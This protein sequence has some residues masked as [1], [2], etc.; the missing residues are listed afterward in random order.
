ET[1]LGRPARERE[2]RLD[3][4][5]FTQ[6]VFGSSS[7]N[8]DVIAAAR[9]FSAFPV[10]METLERMGIRTPAVYV[11]AAR[12]A[13]KLTS[14]DPSRGAVALGQF[15]GALALLERMTRVRTID[16][17]TAEAFAQRLFAVRIEDG[18]YDGSVAAWL[19]ALV[20]RVRTATGTSQASSIDDVILAA[21]A[22]PQ[23]GANAARLEWEG[24]RYRVDPGAAELERLRLTRTRQDAVT[25][26]TAMNVRDAVRTITTSTPAPDALHETART[27]DAAAMEIAAAEQPADESAVKALREAAR[28]LASIRRAADAG[29]ARRAVAPLG[30]VADT[31]LGHALV[32]LAYACD[33]GDPEGTILIAGDPSRRHDYGYDVP[34][35]DG[36]TKAMWGIGAI[37]TRRGPWH[38][39]G[40]VLA[41]DVAMAPLALRRISV[42]RVPDAPMLN[43]M[44][45]DGFA[46]AVAVMNGAALSD[47][48]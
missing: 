11:A 33:L 37:E 25:F 48:D 46:A 5:S 47:A 26:A 4:F 34:G 3:L 14:L 44:H 30:A 1:I 10:L 16:T 38:L 9:G 42:D 15:Q 36:R 13:E 27:L 35:R 28:T 6:R 20:D 8:D 43:L 2:R 22:G 40:S 31:L 23:R 32:S 41:L 39:V 21:A 19:T 17:A 24:Q 18:R 29:D 7:G 45:R 12:H